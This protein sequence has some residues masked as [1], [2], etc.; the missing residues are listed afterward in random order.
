[1]A[2]WQGK[3]AWEG[4]LVCRIQPGVTWPC[5]S[6]GVSRQ[7]GHQRPARD[8]HSVFLNQHQAARTKHRLGLDHLR[9][10]FP[11]FTIPRLFL[12]PKA[13][14]F[15]EMEGLER[16]EK[17]L[18]KRTPRK[19][20]RHGEMRGLRASPGAGGRGR[21]GRVVP[22]LRRD[23][24]ALSQLHQIWVPL[25]FSSRHFSGTQVPPTL[26]P[27]EKQGEFTRQ[28]EPTQPALPTPHLV[29]DLAANSPGWR[30]PEP[31]RGLC[32]PSPKRGHFPQ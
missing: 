7:G 14:L 9:G 10:L 16:E 4:I 32:F 17:S 2:S 23:G 12:C 20:S 25:G 29:M 3:E 11:A 30:D 1:M 21:G 22:R 5:W 26:C 24:S 28:P 15:G 18:R 31:P 8:D 27:A 13:S 19:S 6:L